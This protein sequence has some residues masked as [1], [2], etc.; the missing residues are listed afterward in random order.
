[1]LLPGPPCHLLP[2]P[3][4][5]RRRRREQR[6]TSRQGC[7][8]SIQRDRN[9]AEPSII[10]IISLWRLGRIFQFSDCW[11]FPM[12]SNI[13]TSFCWYM[14]KVEKKN[15][16]KKKREKKSENLIKKWLK[17]IG[18]DYHSK[19][20]LLVQYSSSRRNSSWWCW[21]GVSPRP[22]LSKHF[23]FT[24]SFF[25]FT[26]IAVKVIFT[27]MFLFNS[28]PSK[29]LSFN[30]LLR[31]FGRKFSSPYKEIGKRPF[32]LLNYYWTC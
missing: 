12:K 18:C 4:A 3:I 9:L 29:F 14:W 27:L 2:D 28:S 19:L 10:G 25:V 31:K 8:Q 24:F 13:R 20:S 22:V 7:S 1:M 21:F 5:W 16:E 26:G 17:K 6:R 11:I 32:A 15:E 30:L 23:I